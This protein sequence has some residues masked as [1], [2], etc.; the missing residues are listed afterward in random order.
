MATMEFHQH[1]PGCVWSSDASDLGLAP[2]HFPEEIVARLGGEDV[3]AR[4]V[5]LLRDGEGD[6]IH[7]EY[8]PC[9]GRNERLLVWND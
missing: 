1:A 7:V 4:L 8:V 9:D 5:S 2:G 3:R 6:L